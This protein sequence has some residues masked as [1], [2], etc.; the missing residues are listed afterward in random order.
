MT[1]ARTRELS[2]AL[3]KLARSATSDEWSAVATLFYEEA[4]ECESWRGHRRLRNLADAAS[5]LSDHR[6]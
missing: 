5:A 1:T 6:A 4:C 2:D 3:R